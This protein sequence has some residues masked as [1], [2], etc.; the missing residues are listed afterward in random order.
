VSTFDAVRR[1]AAA[2]GVPDGDIG[3]AGLKD[4]D[5]VATQQ[6]SLPPPVTVE[7]VRA[8]AVPGVRVLAAD[9]HP[10]KLRTGHLRG[11]RFVLTV[12][13]LAVPIDEAVARARAVLERLAAP[14][15]VPNFYGDQRFGLGGANAAL[16]RGLVRGERVRARPRE[17]RFLVSAYQ[18]ELFNAYLE[19]RLKDGLYPRVIEGDVLRK[20]DSGGIFVT[21]DPALDEARVGAGE[22]TVTGP[23]FGAEMR[24]PPSGSAA[25]ARENALLVAEGLCAADF[26]RVA[27]I[28]QGTRR[29]LAVRVLDADARPAAGAL[30]LR[31]TL[32]A[33]AYATVVCGEILKS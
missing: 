7:A 23:M 10:H 14:P 12:R 30:E 21:T 25:A 3:T 13:G 24:G 8:L 31:F 18:S 17:A 5:A 9:R 22:I 27:K 20:N 11:N 15:G 32:P 2:L 1:I 6:V 28:G 26:R 19:Q 33:G 29:P 4:K 16:G